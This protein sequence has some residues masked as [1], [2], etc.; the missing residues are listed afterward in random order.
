MILS[1]DIPSV[2]IDVSKPVFNAIQYW[3]DDVTQLVDRT[4]GGDNDDTSTERANSRD[5]SLI[6]S[7]FFA[8]S[9]SGSG[10]GSTLDT[11]SEHSKNDTSVMILVSEGIYR[12]FIPFIFERV[13]GFFSAFVRIMIPGAKPEFSVRPVLVMASD[14]DILVEL[15]PKGRASDVIHLPDKSLHFR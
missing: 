11:N 5:A 15:K 12:K 14:V 2:Y 10:I 4:F 8:K 7:R 9:R 3:I 13:E 6:G 1:V